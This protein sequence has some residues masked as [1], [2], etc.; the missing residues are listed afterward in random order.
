MLSAVTKSTPLSLYFTEAPAILK[1]DL[2]PKNTSE[3][4]YVHH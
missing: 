3:M 4:H 1:L 2:S